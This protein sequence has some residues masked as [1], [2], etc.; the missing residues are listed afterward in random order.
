M[1]EHWG[2]YDPILLTVDE[3]LNSY[4]KKKSSRWYQEREFRYHLKEKTLS[5]TNGLIS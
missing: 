2:V 4:K 1:H 3:F 5:V